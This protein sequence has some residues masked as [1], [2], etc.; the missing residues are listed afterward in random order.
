MHSD[1]VKLTRG[2]GQHLHHYHGGLRLRH[3][4]KISCLHPTVR[5][6]L[7]ELLVIPLHQHLGVPAEP[8]VSPGN[9]VLKGD[10][11]G[12]EAS[13][14]HIPVHAPTSGR[15]EAIETRGMSQASGIPGCCVLLRPDGED[16]W[17]T[18]QP[19]NDWRAVDSETLIQTIVATGIV[20]LG[21]SVFPTG[22]K[23]EIGKRA[24]IHTLILNGAECEPYISCDE[25]L[26]R[27]RPAEIVLGAQ[28]LQKATG[29]E[30][31]VIAIEDQMG[32]VRRALEPAIKDTGSTDISLIRIK[33]IYPEGGERQLIQV[34]TGQEVPEG[35]YP[36]DIGLI[37]N[38]V[39]TAAAVA[40][41]VTEGKP[42]LERYV[43]VTGN[44]IV[45]PRNFMALLGTP[46]SHLV[47]QCGGYTGDVARI[48]VGGPMM[49]YSLPSDQQPVVKASNC[50]LVLTAQD[51]ESP[52]PEMPCINCGECARVCPAQ[53]LP[54]ELHWQIKN[55]QWEDTESYHLSACI[56]CGCCDLVCPSHIP[57]VEW[58]H[59]AKGEI[60]E[61]SKQ[62]SLADHAR[63]RH[64]A[65]DERLLRIKQDRL[66]R[67][68][69]RK[70]ALRDRAG[71]SRTIAEAIERSESKK[72]MKSPPEP[73]S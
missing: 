71:Q 2:A 57:L 48:V 59:F 30:S 15:I 24:G 64:L 5:P 6:P 34:L 13:S 72:A 52:Q 10:L 67:I 65:R 50:I 3:N 43:T 37:C 7:P 33:S 63:S 12:V 29:A 42:L 18:L 54:Q 47:A 39:A 8:V 9:L 51:L 73:D 4:K 32:E 70:Q 53:L 26:M 61:Q 41:A 46:V 28:I 66:D 36:A 25:M 11:I 17:R 35:G 38:N 44:G 27:E 68:A 69:R 20:G 22:K 58:F 40:T 19:V 31:T 49:G 16:R 62:R 21:G 55:A 45:E 60:R 23:T 1:P 56:E 14:Q